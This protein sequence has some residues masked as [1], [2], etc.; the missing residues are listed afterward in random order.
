VRNFVLRIGGKGTH[1]LGIDRSGKASARP[2]L[3]QVASEPKCCHLLCQP[4]MR[5]ITRL[6]CCAG[7]H[8]RL[9]PARETLRPHRRCRCA[10]SC[11]AAFRAPVSPFNG[12][13]CATT[14]IGARIR[15]HLLRHASR[16]FAHDGTNRRGACCK[17]ARFKP[18]PAIMTCWP[19]TH[20]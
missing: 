9:P 6:H 4:K 5:V 15:C 11:R 13:R 20:R 17:S 16:V 18:N 14:K 8:R 2:L 12:T 10:L 19:A 1:L 7:T 3:A